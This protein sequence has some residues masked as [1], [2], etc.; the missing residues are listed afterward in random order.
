MGCVT[1]VIII[2][3][4]SNF[5]CP[6][7]GVGGVTNSDKEQ[8]LLHLAVEAKDIHLN[9]KKAELKDANEEISCL[10]SQ[11]ASIPVA[12]DSAFAYGNGAGMLRLRSHLMTDPFANLALLDRN[13][14]KPDAAT[15]HYADKIG[16]TEMPDAFKDFPPPS[17][18]VGNDAT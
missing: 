10:C 5:T 3:D 16:Q 15:H 14:F 18:P 1:H 9:E 12:R 17:S 4:A 11:L 2:P 8:R 6:Y 7:V 13:L